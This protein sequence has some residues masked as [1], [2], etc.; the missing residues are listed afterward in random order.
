MVDE[1]FREEKGYT[2][3]LETWIKYMGDYSKLM[4]GTDWPLANLENYIQFTKRLIPEKA[5]GGGVCG[6]R[7]PGLRPG[8]LDRRL[9]RGGNGRHL[10]KNFLQPF[11]T[12]AMVYN[13]CFLKGSDLS[14]ESPCE[15]R[16]CKA[17]REKNLLYLL[18]QKDRV[19]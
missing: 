18:R 8:G 6:Q 11:G 3:Y 17:G 4:Y 13:S 2:D 7:G 1:F 19:L 16:R 15:R 5:L 14:G 9:K 10:M 12:C